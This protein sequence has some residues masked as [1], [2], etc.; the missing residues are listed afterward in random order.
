MGSFYPRN[1]GIGLL[2]KYAKE[3]SPEEY[4]KLYHEHFKFEYYDKYEYKIQE[5][6]NRDE[7]ELIADFK[8]DYLDNINDKETLHLKYDEEFIKKILNLISTSTVNSNWAQIVITLKNYGLIDLALHVSKRKS[9]YNMEL[10]RDLIKIFDLPLPKK[11]YKIEKLFDLSALDN[12]EE[13]MKLLKIHKYEPKLVMTR[14]KDYLLHGYHKKYDHEEKS[15]YISKE[16]IDKMKK[17][18][19]SKESKIILLDTS[20]GTG[21]STVCSEL[22]DHIKKKCKTKKDRDN[23]KILCPISRRTM[24]A[25]LQNAFQ[26]DKKKINVCELTS[27]LKFNF[28]E[29]VTPNKF[30]VSLEKLGRINESSNTYNIVILD[31]ITSLLTHFYSSTMKDLRRMALIN[32][33]NYVLK[34]DLVIACDANIT[35]FV[36]GFFNELCPN[37]VF[38]YRNNYQNKQNIP[39]TVYLGCKGVS[40]ELNIES[41]LKSIEQA[42]KDKESIFIISDS[43]R[44]VEKIYH[45]LS[46][47]SN[48]ITK[49][50]ND[51]KIK[52]K[53]NNDSRKIKK[54]DKSSDESIDDESS[55]DKSNDDKSGIESSDES[56]DDESSDESID[57][58]SS[59]EES[60]NKK[61]KFKKSDK[62]ADNK[63]NKKVNNKKEYDSE[64]EYSDDEENTK[65]KKRKKEK[66]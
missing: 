58:E 61:I 20:T 23:T 49:E 63:T 60:S 18:V 33:A 52:G 59:D 38:H 16:A 48:E 40:E 29:K 65:S 34:A 30:I 64:D 2:K 13:A 54:N 43:K 4:F 56:I 35:S 15:K 31:E 44:Y 25:T 36:L 50:E 24:V 9:N 28:G 53:K 57:D 26:N 10:I 55:D 21:K 41:F 14:S 6:D 47:F 32:L 12:Y 51:K 8:K 7:K 62:K 66:I 46:K 37:Q 27:Y 5:V 42:V 39:M 19:D 1:K 3:D 45:Y 22:T 11:H 17:V